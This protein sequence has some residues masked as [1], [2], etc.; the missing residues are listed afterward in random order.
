MIARL[1]A[2]DADRDAIA[3]RDAHARER[4]VTAVPTF[5]VG[6][7]YALSGAQPAALWAEVIAEIAASR[8]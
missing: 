2:S 6:N 3:A 7:Q 4:G 8:G 1:L 5:I